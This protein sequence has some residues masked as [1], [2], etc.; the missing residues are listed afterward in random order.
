MS[1]LRE[2]GFWSSA[3][4]CAWVLGGYPLALTLLPERPWAS[5]DQLPRVTVLIPTYREFD[6]LPSKLASLRALDYPRELLQVVVAVDGDAALAELARAEDPEA[7]VCLVPERA[8][9]PT[10][11]NLGLERADG[12]I[13]LLT[14]AHNPLQPA[15]VRTA[16]RHFADPAIWGVTGRWAEH[17]SAYDRYEHA[18]RC[19]ETRSGS[20]AGVFGGFVAVRRERLPRFPPDIVNEDFWLLCRLV[21]GGGRVIYEPEAKSGTAGLAPAQELERRMR[22]SAGRVLAISELRTLPPGFS[23]RLLSHKVGRLALPFLLLG[24]LLGSI[25]LGSRRPYRRL[26]ALQASLYGVGLLGVAGWTPPGAGG[27]LVRAAGQFTLGNLA[28]GLGV[29]RGVRRRQDVF[30]KPVR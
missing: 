28:V 1:R 12:E 6:L 17:G 14:D 15:S 4:G 23:W 26:A 22:I 20:V 30:W 5:E 13:V 24:T 2:L 16:M 3:S 19:L 7:V 9:K 27:R 11:L 10:A 25:S 8:G 18:I 29:V 21:G